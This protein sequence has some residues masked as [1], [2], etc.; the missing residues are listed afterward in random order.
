MFGRTALVLPG[1]GSLCIQQAGGLVGLHQAGFTPH[2]LYGASGGGLNGALYY[3]DRWDAMDELWSTIQTPNVY[4]SDPSTWWR[5][6]GS[7]A[8]LYDPAPLLRTIR[9]YVGAAVVPRLDLKFQISATDILCEQAD[10][11]EFAQLADPALF[12]LASASV[13]VFF[14]PVEYEGR[15]LVDGGVLNNYQV[16]QA[17]RDGAETIVI[18]S[19]SIWSPRDRRSIRNAA[20][21]L[22]ATISAA[23]HGYLERELLFTQILNNVEGYRDVRIIKIDLPDM[24]RRDL[25]DFNLGPLAHRR[26]VMD[27]CRKIARRTI[28]RAAG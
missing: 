10:T 27:E 8:S 15:L 7:S 17:I 1:G 9:R 20:S 3:A 2:L 6:G 14:P 12:L 19:P 13:P 5:A 11:R 28:E 16:A 25:L 4:R 22:S 21:M 24:T 23:M 26:W 18:L